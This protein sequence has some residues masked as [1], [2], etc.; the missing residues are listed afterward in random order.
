MPKKT[1]HRKNLLAGSCCWICCTPPWGWGACAGWT[2]A[3]AADRP[4]PSSS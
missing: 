2:G 4:I 1:K 3:P